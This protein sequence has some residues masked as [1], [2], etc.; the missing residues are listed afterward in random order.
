M[1]SSYTKRCKACKV[2]IFRGWTYTEDE[3]NEIYG[4]YDGGAGKCGVCG[5]EFCHDCGE[6]E[7]GA[8]KDCRE[9]T[10]EGR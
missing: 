4:E 6:I 2:I 8:C 5:K 9:E 7:G 3:H 10:G 1:R